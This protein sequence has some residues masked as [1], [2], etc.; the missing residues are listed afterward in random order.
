MSV[1]R[2]SQKAKS[3][4]VFGQP[5]RSAKMFRAGLYARVS[6][7]DQQV[8]PMQKR[9]HGSTPLGAA[10]RLQC[11]DRSPSA[12]RAYVRVATMAMT[13]ETAVG[14]SELEQLR[15]RF[16]E[17]RVFVRHET[18]YVPRFR[19]SNLRLPGDTVS[20]Q[21]RKRIGG[22]FRT[23]GRTSP[24]IDPPSRFTSQ[25]RSGIRLFSCPGWQLSI[26][27]L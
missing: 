7:N 10:G 24:L 9:P 2:A 26:S 25:L 4:N 19:K 13:Q 22:R 8:L 23:A 12:Y 16:E 21:P 18:G 11:G 27:E 6:T 14:D 1:K 5:R 3:D 17:Y 20:I 15:R